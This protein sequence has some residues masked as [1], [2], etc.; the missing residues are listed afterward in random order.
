VTELWKCGRCN[1]TKPVSG[2]YLRKGKP[3]TAWCK[4]CYREWHRE[5]YQPQGSA[6][7]DAR[8]CD[9]C[10]S[11]YRPGQRRRSRYCSRTCKERAANRA[12]QA[13][14]DAAKPQ[15]ECLHCARVLPSEMRSDARFCS[16]RCNEAAHALQRKLRA[17]TGQ[18][19]KPGHLRASICVRDQWICGI[20]AQPV[21]RD[22]EY[23]DPLAP[24]L[25]HVVPVSQGGTNDPANL[26]LV[27]LVCNLRR[28]HL[29]GGE[30][31]ALI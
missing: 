26:R 15:R 8:R 1:T 24:S 6:T 29:G 14:I 7:D 30:Q 25:D 27:H 11:T 18:D 4:E 12:R 13:A 19:D 2:F 31:L 23:P 9:E 10:A 20:C 17:R 28:R 3:D 16:K 5:R 21:A 22:R